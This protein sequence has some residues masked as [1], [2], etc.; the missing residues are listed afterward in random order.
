M[1]A[2]G[3]TGDD[4]GD[5]VAIFHELVKSMELI[6]RQIDLLIQVQLWPHAH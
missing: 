2:P 1:C 3:M 5:W 6:L 4:R